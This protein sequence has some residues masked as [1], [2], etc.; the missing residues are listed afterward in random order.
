MVTWLSMLMWWW[1]CYWV[2]W[3]GD[4]HVTE[5]IEVVMIMLLSIL[6]C[7]WSCYWVYWCGDGH[8]TEY[9]D[10]MMV[11]WL[12]KLMWWWSRAW[13]CR[14]KKD[15]NDWSECLNL[16]EVKVSCRLI[17]LRNLCELK[18]KHLSKFRCLLS[19]FITCTSS[20]WYSSSSSFLA[21]SSKIA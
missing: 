14:M 8:V 12:S 21:C 5:Y 16:R 17:Y 6:M 3:C 13:C 10:V 11:T 15:F 2:Y 19:I 1:S 4:D 20:I 18:L 7:W 9:V